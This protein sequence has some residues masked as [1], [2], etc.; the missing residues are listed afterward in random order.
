MAW[1]EV[2]IESWSQLTDMFEKMD[3]GRPSGLTFL[4]RGQSNAGWR[5]IDN[6]SRLLEESNAGREDAIWA[7]HI[8]QESYRRFVAQAHQ[9]LD[10]SSLPE[11]GSLLAW[12]AL[13]QHFGAPTRL[14]DWTA[15]PFIAA[16]FAVVDSLKS[17]GAIWAFD[18]SILIDATV[19]RRGSA[20]DES[21]QSDTNSSW[22]F[23]GPRAD[24]ELIY[25]YH[26]EKHH[27]RIS[28]QQGAFTVCGTIPGDHEQAIDRVIG[29][30]IH[31]S[32]FKFIIAFE[33]KLNMLRNLMRMN[34]T[35]NSLF[36]GLDGLGRSIKEFAQVAAS[37]R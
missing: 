31:R 19:V 21:F 26:P 29:N 23:W 4:F 6:L 5:L 14:L 34:I 1:D 11:E 33:L 24:P 18:A 2:R 30:N 17:P 28:T 15:S 37:Y 20:P 35:S 8:E 27:V 16:Y 32:V 3:Y 36:P 9:F 7:T 22:I 13:M 10:P 12:W 25:P